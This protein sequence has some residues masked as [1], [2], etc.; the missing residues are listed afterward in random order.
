MLIEPAA[1]FDPPNNARRRAAIRPSE[2]RAM[3]PILPALFGPAL[4]LALGGC[5]GDANPVRDAA[6]AAGV[7]GGEPKPAPDFVARSRP[8]EVDYVPI[9][10]SAPPRRYRAKTKDEVEGA[11][12]QMNRVGRANAARAAG[13]RRDAG[14]P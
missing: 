1:I 9:G 6:L 2:T 11:E 12:A 8:A 13:A 5:A 10:V 7:T 14:A 4:A 3:R